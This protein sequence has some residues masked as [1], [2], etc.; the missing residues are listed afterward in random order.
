MLKWGTDKADELGLEA[1]IESTDIARTAYE[2]HGFYV[3]G[4]LNMD[5][6]SEAESEEFSA[7]R[8]KLGCPIHGWIMKRDPLS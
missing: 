2:K 5:A 1:F 8:D 3:I 6:Q 7:M 4:E